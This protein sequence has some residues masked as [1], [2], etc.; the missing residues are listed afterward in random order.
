MA[1]EDENHL[2]EEE[3]KRRAAE[4]TDELARKYD[5]ERLT[6]IV[7]SD[8]GKGEKLD[9]ATRLE[10]EKKLGGNFA[11][12]R[13]FRGPFAEAVTKQHRADAVTVAATGMILVREG[14]RSDPRTALGKALLAHELTH[15]KQAQEGLHFA[16]EDGQAGHGAH[17]QEAE[18]VE[19]AVH[20]QE[21]GGGGG[22]DGAAAGVGDVEAK[23]IAK[24]IELVEEDQR[25]RGE[26]LGKK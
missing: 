23:V 8:A 10:M 2:S 14:P 22:G 15:V 26:R 21:T 18:R 3:R 24:V 7:V 4:L 16:H 1:A 12:V 13:V 25:L 11:D 17:E 5:P 6:Q 20:A 19:S 9:L